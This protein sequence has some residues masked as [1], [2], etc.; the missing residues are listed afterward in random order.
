MGTS[1]AVA[2]LVRFYLARLPRA[3]AAK[4]ARKMRAHL[5]A[6]RDDVQSY[7]S[8]Y[9]PVLIRGLNLGF[10]QKADVGGH[11]PEIVRWIDTIVQPG[12]VLW[13]IGAHSG[14]YSIYAAR[15]GVGQVYAFEPFAGTYLNLTQNIIANGVDDRVRA[16]NVALFDAPGIVDLRVF[17]FE[18]I[19][20]S[21]V[22]GYEM[23]FAAEREV[24]GRQSV[25]ALPG[26][27]FVAMVPEAAPDHIKLDVDGTE[28]FVL[29]GLGD[30]LQR[31]TSLYIEVEPRFRAEFD[32]DFV[33]LLQT[34]G[35]GEIPIAEPACGRNRL[36]LRASANTAAIKAL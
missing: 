16:L 13:D 20:T 36:F 35:L 8:R 22:E 32:A 23:P 24:L 3:Y 25:L 10:G 31:V 6:Y 33:P 14:L 27:Q 21:T 15:R 28:A 9:G 1:S 26:R 2:H 11:E 30:V 19:T 7:D 12:A 29:R 5:D 17:S 34:M 4:T 18:P